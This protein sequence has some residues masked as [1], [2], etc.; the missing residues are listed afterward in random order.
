MSALG[1]EDIAMTAVTGT[2]RRRARALAEPLAF[3]LLAALLVYG[4]ASTSGFLTWDNVKAILASM[5]FVGIVAVGM[6]LIMIGGNLFSLSLGTT[7]AVTAMAFLAA[8]RFGV[9]PAIAISVLLGAAIC[10][11]QGVLVGGLAANPIIV[12]IAAGSLQAGAAS[13]I[14]GGRSIQPSATAHAYSFLA[15]PILGIPFSIYVLLALVVA[16]ELLLRRTRAGRQL[17]LVGESRRAA[18]VA[19][20]PVTRVTTIAFAL[21]GACAA[22]AG[23][24]IGAF[25]QN[26]SLLLTGTYTYDAISAAIVG[27]NAING[28]RG[29]VLRSVLG[30]LVIATVTDLML[31]RHYSTGAQI[32]VKGVI[33]IVFVIVLNSTRLGRRA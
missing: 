29:S 1:A 8:L 23:V 13:G 28:G 7:T 15:D 10:A 3:V 24:L 17:Y 16:G 32:L 33:V 11:V 26:A 4:A 21:A 20:L 14:S 12:T 25:N 5:G 19:G 31:L 27:G 30:A 22:V 6:T 18:F 9:V 2:A